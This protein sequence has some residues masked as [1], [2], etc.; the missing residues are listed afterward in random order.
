M[1]LILTHNDPDGVISAALLLRK[2]P[3]FEVEFTVP[4]QLKSKLA[5]Y[6]NKVNEREHLIIS[7]LAGDQDSLYL[8]A[9]WKKVNWFDHHQWGEIEEIPKRVKLVVE[10]KPSAAQVIA[11]KLGFTNDPLV[12]IA[13]ELDTN[14]IESEEAQALRFLL[15]EWRRNFDMDVYHL[16]LAK[17]ARELAEKGLEA[18]SNYKEQIE[19]FRKEYERKV[20]SYV[21]KIRGLKVKEI[22]GKKVLF[23]EVNDIPFIVSDA[24][25]KVHSDIDIIVYIR[26]KKHGYRYELRSQTGFPVIYICKAL[27][28]GG[29]KVA[30]GANTTLPPEEL[31]VLIKRVIKLVKEKNLEEVK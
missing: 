22:E 11:D 26:K 31:E 13:N 25:E 21:E 8:A 16:K 28:G 7:D 4:S 6:V 14:Q 3:D 17:F 27:G 2:F 12:K 9:I 10:L 5:S 30:C 15:A 24:L 29:H 23:V 19:R 20:S 1:K 18:L